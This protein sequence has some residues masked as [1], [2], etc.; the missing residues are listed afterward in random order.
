MPESSTKEVLRLNIS[1]GELSATL[2]KPEPEFIHEFVRG[3][4]ERTLL[5]S[6][7][8]G[9]DERNLIPMGHALD[10]NAFI[11]QA[12][13][14]LIPETQPDLFSARVWID[15]GRFN[16][17]ILASQTQFCESPEQILPFGLL[18]LATN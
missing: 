7:G 4:S 8:T 16:P 3:N 17:I 15:A 2:V 18:Q 1:N 9:G 14:P 12:M 5:L 10:A 11:A 13:V 6:H